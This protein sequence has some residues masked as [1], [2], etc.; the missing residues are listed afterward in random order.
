MIPATNKDFGL[1]SKEGTVGSSAAKQVTNVPKKDLP[2][3][4]SSESGT[5]IL[6]AIIF[7]PNGQLAGTGTKNMIVRFVEANR[8]EANESGTPKLPL[9][10]N[11]VTCK[12][13][14]LD[15]GA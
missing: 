2:G 13:K 1:T 11:W 12:A 14:F 5:Q 8:Y 3:A 4:S 7:K 15:P 9:N 6:K 10:I